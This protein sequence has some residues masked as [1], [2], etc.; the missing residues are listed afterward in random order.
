MIIEK[1]SYQI[2]I[3]SFSTVC[4]SVIPFP[5]EREIVKCTIGESFSGDEII[6]K[7]IVTTYG[8]SEKI[9]KYIKEVDEKA[10]EFFE[11]RR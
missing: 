4:I 3:E 9:S 8:L 1:F 2:Y 10:L 6:F 11:E 5:K 7:K